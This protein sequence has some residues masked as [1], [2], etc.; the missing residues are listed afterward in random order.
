[1]HCVVA[2]CVFARGHW[3]A[4]SSWSLRPVTAAVPC[5]LTHALVV[6]AARIKPGQPTLPVNEYLSSVENRIWISVDLFQLL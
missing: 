6:T 5:G 4:D 3:Y 1:M 2:K